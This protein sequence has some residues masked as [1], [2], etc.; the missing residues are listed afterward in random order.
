MSSRT[1][2]AQI[3]DRS[4]ATAWSPIAEYPC[5]IALGIKVRDHDTIV[6]D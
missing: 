6:D 3:N 2:I 4:A 5:A 1:K